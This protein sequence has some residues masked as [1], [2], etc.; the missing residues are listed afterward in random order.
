MT[1]NNII[2][3]LQILRPFYKKP[4]GYNCGANHDVIYGYAT[5]SPL[6]EECILKMIEL[7]WHQE[8]DGR[9]YGE[10]FSLKDY[11]ED[12]SWHAYC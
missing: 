8:Y 1:T 7:G 12:E 11:R 4:D 3:G 10:E 6:P 5:D 2:Q 9:D